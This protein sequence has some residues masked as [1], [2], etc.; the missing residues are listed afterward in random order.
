MSDIRTINEDYARIGHELIDTE[1]ALS[2]LRGMPYSIIYL[3]SSHSK[4]HKGNM[5]LGQCEKVLDKNKWAVPCDF[6]ITVFEPNCE[7]LTEDQIKILLFH[8]LLHVGADQD[9]PY[10]KPH[11]LEDFKLIID[12]FGVDWCKREES[13]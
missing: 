12:R 5:V 11:D 10:V 4:K 3:S 8:E 1:E 7:G 9:E 6:T 2:N 13:E